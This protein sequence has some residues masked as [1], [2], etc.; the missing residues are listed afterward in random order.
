MEIQIYVKTGLDKILWKNNF[1]IRE[2]YFRINSKSVDR[3]TP[4]SDFLGGCTKYYDLFVFA[5]IIA[6]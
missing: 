1:E 6:I 4:D 3:S 5:R 2:K